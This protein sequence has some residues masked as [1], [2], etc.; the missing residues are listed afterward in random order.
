MQ[1][2]MSVDRMGALAAT[3][4][5]A[6]TFLYHVKVGWSEGARDSRGR[7]TDGFDQSPDHLPVSLAGDGCGKTFSMG[8]A[9]KGV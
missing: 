9:T 4:P 7:A 3:H 8:L 2:A 1:H 6:A 5:F